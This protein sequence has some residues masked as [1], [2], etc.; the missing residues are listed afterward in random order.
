MQIRELA[1]RLR[2]VMAKVKLTMRDGNEVQVESSFGRTYQLEELQPYGLA[3]KAQSGHGLLL[4]VGGNT[5]SPLLLPICSVEGR[6]DLE[7]GEVAVFHESGS[8]IV[9]KK[10][11]SI[12]IGGS[13]YGGLV[14]WPE[15]QKE[16]DKLT[17]MWQSL[18][19]ALSVP[20][21]EAGNGAPSVFQQALKAA[22]SGK[23]LPTWQD[24]ESKYVK[25]GDTGNE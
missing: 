23:Q 3:S 4:F 17:E 11:G 16:L 25:H 7:D 12:E 18:V 20:V 15:L 14:R 24:V 19:Q 13:S 9:L 10:D 21:N 6:P 22:L 5:Q 1:A 8:C 2:N